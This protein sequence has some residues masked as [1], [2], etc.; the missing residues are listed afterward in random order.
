LPTVALV[1]LI[2]EPPGCGGYRLVKS[3]WYRKC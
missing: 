1:L 2:G 3:T